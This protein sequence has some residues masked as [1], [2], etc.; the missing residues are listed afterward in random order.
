[1]LLNK[2]VILWDVKKVKRG[3]NLCGNTI[4][5]EMMNSITIK[6]WI[7][8]RKDNQRGNNR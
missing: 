8:N 4:T 5:L 6:Q 2:E 1:M 3:N 7:I